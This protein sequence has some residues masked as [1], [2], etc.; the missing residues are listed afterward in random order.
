[1]QVNAC[2]SYTCIYKLFASLY[3]HVYVRIWWYL[4][5]YDVYAC[6]GF[7]CACIF[8]ND[9]LR[10]WNR[11][12][13]PEKHSPWAAIGGPHSGHPRASG[14]PLYSAVGKGCADPIWRTPPR[15]TRPGPLKRPSRFA[16]RSP[17]HDPRTIIQSHG[18]PQQIWPV[19]VHPDARGRRLHPLEN[20]SWQRF[21]DV[22]ICMYMYVYVCM[23]M[24]MYVYVC[25]LDV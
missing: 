11:C 20:T 5:V 14:H 8:W 19:G 12:H 7:V 10:H 24:Y 4:Y 3:M 25:I 1:M 16:R 2:I 13:V 17:M 22:C 15:G 21:A 18:V 23:C 9:T 6:I